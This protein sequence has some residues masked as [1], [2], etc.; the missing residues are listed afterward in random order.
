M[1]DKMVP[2]SYSCTACLSRITVTNCR[3]EAGRVRGH[4][5]VKRNGILISAMNYI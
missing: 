1:R 3:G 2:M 5:C 4:A